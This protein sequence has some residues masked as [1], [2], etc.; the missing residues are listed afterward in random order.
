[1]QYTWDPAKNAANIRKHGVDF[2]DAPRL[3]DGPMLVKPDRRRDYGEK[4][5]IA[6]GTIEGIIF[7]LVY[8]DRS[9]DERRV[10]SFRSAGRKERHVFQEAYP[11]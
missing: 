11:L 6:L 3:F 5:F 7:S 10:I 2:A 8:T 9:A 4:R 1:M